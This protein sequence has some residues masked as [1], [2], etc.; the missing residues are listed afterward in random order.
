VLH[1]RS[2]EHGRNEGSGGATG[3]KGRR[4]GNASVSSAFL[5][6]EKCLAQAIS[7]AHTDTTSSATNTLGSATMIKTTRLLE[8]YSRLLS[9]LRDAKSESAEAD[10]VE[11]LGTQVR[12]AKERIE[13]SQKVEEETISFR[14][15]S[16]S[17]HKSLGLDPVTCGIAGQ[18]SPKRRLAQ[19]ASCLRCSP[20]SLSP[21]PTP[22]SLPSTSSIHSDVD[23]RVTQRQP[24]QRRPQSRRWR[25]RR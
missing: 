14:L 10:Y 16:S 3:S 15:F 2:L 5:E 7:S 25:R 8:D 11:M 12:H 6:G 19:H 24:A 23:S 21:R 4:E 18:T 17:G 9:M 1:S 13:Y 22:P 20:S